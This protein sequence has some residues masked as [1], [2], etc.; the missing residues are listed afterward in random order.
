MLSWKSRQALAALPIIIGD[1]PAMLDVLAVASRVADT[2]AGVL[3]EGESGTGK[4]LL[5]RL[6]HS[7][8][9]RRDRPFVPVNCAVLT[10]DGSLERELFGEERVGPDGPVHGGKLEQASGGTLFLDE[11]G[12]LGSAEQAR[13]LRVLEEGVVERPGGERSTGVD[14]R[15]IAAASRPLRCEVG[16]GHFRPDLYYRIAVVVLAL[17]PLRERGDDVRMLAEHF[18]GGYAYANDRYDFALAGSTLSLL[19]AHP[20]PGNVRQLKETVEQAASAAEGPLLRP[21]DFSAEY[22]DISKPLTL[23]QDDAELV[24]LNE[25]ERLH[26]EAVLAMTG[27]KVDH[28]ARLLGID[29]I[30]LRRRLRRHGM[31]R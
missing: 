24:P 9:R 3:I 17:P 22:R 5:A 28:A 14:V 29:Q 2:T 20:W 4:G 23:H 13:V 30:A 1:S 6:I 7:R 19:E 21:C 11:I 15:V 18:V 10:A 12:E 8:S 31:V 26:I 27:G 16:A 25:V